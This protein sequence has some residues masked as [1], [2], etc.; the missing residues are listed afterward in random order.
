MFKTECHDCIWESD[1]TT[2][3][4][5]CYECGYERPIRYESSSTTRTNP[6][7]NPR[8]E[9]MTHIATNARSD[10]TNVRANYQLKSEIRN[11]LNGLHFTRDMADR[12]ELVWTDFIRVSSTHLMTNLRGQRRVACLVMIVLAIVDDHKNNDDQTNIDHTHSVQ[13][14]LSKDQNDVVSDT[15]AAADTAVA[16]KTASDTAQSTAL[17]TV[18]Y[19]VSP[20]VLFWASRFIERL[21][22]KLKEP[23]TEPSSEPTSEPTSESSKPTNDHI[24]VKSDTHVC[25]SQTTSAASQKTAVDVE[26]L[27]H[28]LDITKYIELDTND[29][30]MYFMPDIWDQAK[31]VFANLQYLSLRVFHTG[32][33]WVRVGDRV[34]MAISVLVAYVNKLWKPGLAPGGKYIR[35]PTKKICQLGFAPRTIR[36]PL[37]QLFPY[38]MIICDKKKCEKLLRLYETIHKW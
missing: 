30:S 32:G 34:L 16:D 6:V 10:I 36:C 1:Y 33:K 26:E 19:R 17:S 28:I 21:T 4:E 7:M 29:W 13:T 20:S 18:R 14:W 37:K 15:D 12:I 31:I 25:K 9:W 24:N 3:I 27:I 11:C 8:G 38:R 2:S 5:I 22:E 23:T 35:N